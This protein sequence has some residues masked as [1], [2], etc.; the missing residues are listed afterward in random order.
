ME[1]TDYIDFNLIRSALNVNS[2]LFSLYIKEIYADLSSRPDSDKEK[3]ISMN[4]FSNYLKLPMYI[5][6]KIFASWDKDNNDCLDFKEFSY[7]MNKIF[8]G[9]FEETAKMIFSI[10]DFDKD[11]KI[12]KS[13][14][15]L[16]L[17]YLP[18]KSDSEINYKNQM[19]SF[20]DLDQILSDTFCKSENLDFSEYLQVIENKKSDIYIQLICF[21]YYRKP[22]EIDSI[23]QY[24][25]LKKN[26]KESPVVK[27]NFE[28]EKQFPSPSKETKLEPAEKLLTLQVIKDFEDSKSTT[29]G[30][31]SGNSDGYSG[32]ETVT[33]NKKH[34][35]KT[36]FHVDAV[37]MPNRKITTLDKTNVNDM[38]A[39]TKNFYNSPTSIIKNKSRVSEFNMESSLIRMNNIEESNIKI[40]KE[41]WVYI[42]E[43]GKLKK[44]YCYL[45]GS[46]MTFYK[47]DSK[48]ELISIQ[49]LSGCFLK[50]HQK[51]TKL[52]QKVKYYGCSIIISKNKEKVF[53]FSKL[54]I[55]DS[56]VN[57][58][59][60]AIGYETFSDIYEVNSV[61]GEGLFGV[62]K[63][64]IHKKTNEVVAVK[65]ITKEKLQTGEIDLIRTEI[66]LMKLFRH[67]N[68]V[69]L[70]D[71]FE[72]SENIYIVMEYL[73]GGTLV[74]YLENKNKKLDEKIIA[75]IMHNIGSV[76]KYINS[77]GVIHRDLK[78]ENIMLTDKGDNPTIKMIDFGLTRTLAD[79]EKIADGFGTVAYVAPEVL[80]RKPYNK[81][82]DIWSMGVILYFLIS[83]GKLPF[84]DENND[85]EKIAKKIVLMDPTF[86]EESFNNKKSLIKF[87]NDCLNKDPEKRISIDQFIKSDWIKFTANA[88]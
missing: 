3:G 13:D 51:E 15:K 48:D 68:I 33:K 18:I 2:N 39:T 38:L 52:F 70:I 46:E 73:E 16:L 19:E 79:G 74:D 87:I 35:K 17:S 24:C 37:R 47:S 55:K 83:G 72:C 82:I 58:I 78:P 32:E 53:Y 43:D 76:I 30:S 61:L 49:N 10:Y 26:K 64:G 12:R 62:V 41:D 54:E 59:K 28:K 63:K 80:T 23:Y 66:D 20:N 69:K 8:L 45:I 42:L 5:S 27:I 31:N 77:Y 65:I 6:K 25:N 9:T 56:W 14:V 60:R 84:S 1:C 36:S 75:K 50:D 86:P 11:G 67:P 22:F 71:H 29:N 88:K 4:T 81:Q 40:N 85:E 57:M 21:I 7:G 34:F 44:I